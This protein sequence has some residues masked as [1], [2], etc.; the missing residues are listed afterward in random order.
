MAERRMF[1]KTIINSG[2]FLRMPATARL[3]YYDLGMMADDDGIVEAYAVMCQTK[4]SEDDLN[5]LVDKGFIK[6]LNEDLVAVICDWKTNN[7]IRSDRYKPSAYAELLSEPE[8]EE[9]E[10]NDIP[11]NSKDDTAEENAV[12]TNDNQLATN[13]IPTDTEVHPQVRLGKDRIYNNNTSADKSAVSERVSSSEIEKEFDELWNKY[14]R[15]EGRK[16]AFAAYRKAR[17]RKEKPCSF[18]QVLKG[19][20]EYSNRIRGSDPRYIKQGQTY[21]IGECW[22]DEFIMANDRPPDPAIEKYNCMINRF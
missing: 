18:E 12:N 14:P 19:I 8:D 9:T 2:R 1:A 20:A 6:I 4:A 11:P 7:S 17:L 5:T 22:N 3:L 21:F 16:K 10:N 13:G 15:K